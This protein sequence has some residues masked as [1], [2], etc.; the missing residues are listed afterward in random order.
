MFRKQRG[1]V[2]R[3]LERKEE[4]LTF[5]KAVQVAIEVED[6]TNVA[7]ETANGARSNVIKIQKKDAK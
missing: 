4:E 2:K 6:S 1:G 7:K 3:V 5:V